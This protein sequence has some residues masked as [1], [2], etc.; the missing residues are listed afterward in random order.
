MNL[1]KQS[2]ILDDPL[3]NAGG[4]S[5][6]DHTLMQRSWETCSLPGEKVTEMY[7]QLH[8]ISF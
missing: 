7:L 6:K 3:I 4:K 1:D 2:E 5:N 8:Y